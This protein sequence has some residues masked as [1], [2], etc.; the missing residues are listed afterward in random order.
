M[1]SYQNSRYIEAAK[2]LLRSE[3]VGENRAGTLKNIEEGI[4]DHF[5]ELARSLDDSEL[6][7][8]IQRDRDILRLY[9]TKTLNYFQAR[10]ISNPQ[11]TQKVGRIASRRVPVVDLYIEYLKLDEFE[12]ETRRRNLSIPLH[13]IVDI[14][15]IKS[16]LSGQDDTKITTNYNEVKK[17]I[18]DSLSSEEL[19]SLT[20]KTEQEIFAFCQRKMQEKTA[21]LKEREREAE[22]KWRESK[23]TLDERTLTELHDEMFRGNRQYVNAV[24]EEFVKV[25]LQYHAALSDLVVLKQVRKRKLTKEPLS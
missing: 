22:E 18:L 17:K 24:H 3:L 1:E 23:L 13:N 19:K 12:K 25:F 15:T 21:Q 8:E 5:K 2:S 6:L 14:R 20:G 7:R 4:S 11:Q 10:L 9:E 16:Y